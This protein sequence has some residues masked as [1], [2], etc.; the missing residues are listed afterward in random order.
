MSVFSWTGFMGEKGNY[1][2][3]S[4]PAGEV[5][6][7]AATALFRSGTAAAF[8]YVSLGLMAVLWILPV[9]FLGLGDDTVVLR[10]NAYFG[11]DL[12]GSTWQTLLVPFMTTFFFSVNSVLAFLFAR[13]NTVFPGT[14]LMVASFFLHVS[15]L[16]A[17]GALLLVN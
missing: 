16:I 17:L 11:I 13:K 6:S 12:T 14:L 15:A 1:G 4:T 7:R 3:A 2:T 5:S 10:Y 8:F 9:A